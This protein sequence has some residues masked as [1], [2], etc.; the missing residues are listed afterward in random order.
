MDINAIVL[1]HTG[2]YHVKYTFI[3]AVVMQVISVVVNVTWGKHMNI[4]ETLIIVIHVVAFLLLVGMLAFGIGTGTVS[5]D[6]SFFTFTGWSPAFGTV[7]GITYVVG[8]FSGFDSVS[9]LSKHNHSTHTPF[10][11][12]PLS[13][14][15]HR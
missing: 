3:T 9:H 14:R 15:G 2:E 8:V 7:L 11:A 10:K 6:F 5:P 4:P 13:S 1:I 12:Y